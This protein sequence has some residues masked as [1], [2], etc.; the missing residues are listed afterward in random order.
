[1]E[2]VPRRIPKNQLNSAKAANEWLKT[3]RKMAADH[4]LLSAGSDGNDG[5]D[6]VP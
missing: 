3:V 4:G 1:V 6:G 2:E 5:N